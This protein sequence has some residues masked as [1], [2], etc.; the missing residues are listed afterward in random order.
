MIDRLEDEIEIATVMSGW[1]RRDL[2]QWDALARL[3][4]PHATIEITWFR[5]TATEFVEG[6][7]KTG[8]SDLVS[9]HLIGTPQLQFNGTKALAETPAIIGVQN[10]KLGLGATTHAR[11]L[12]RVEKRDNCWRIAERHCS[13]DI[14][15]F[16]FPRG[17][18]EIDIDRLDRHRPEYAPLG[19]LLDTAGFPVEGPFPTRGSD[20]ETKVREDAGDWLVV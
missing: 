4:H 15:T 19:Y 16:D 8:A 9:R 1:L 5:G 17:P 7:R 2:A 13:Y 18:V 12:D 3:F 6:S 10:C 20:L 14:S 11:F